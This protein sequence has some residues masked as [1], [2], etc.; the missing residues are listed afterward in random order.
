MR[1][2]PHVS[3]PDSVPNACQ[4]KFHWTSPRSS[5]VFGCLGSD[6]IFRIARIARPCVANII[7]LQTKDETETRMREESCK[8][9]GG[10]LPHCSSLLRAMCVVWWS[11]F[12]YI[13]KNIACDRQC[14]GE[15]LT[16][17]P[18]R[19][20]SPFLVFAYERLQRTIYPQA[21]VLMSCFTLYC[22]RTSKSALSR[23]AFT[24]L[25]DAFK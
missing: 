2:S 8:Q 25:F 14:A 13:I 4:R 10:T 7:C 6:Q 9:L 12:A 23:Q 15:H 17:S 16:I 19:S 1:E 18:T 24:R 20:V 11:E 3:E 21:I 22:L 5:F